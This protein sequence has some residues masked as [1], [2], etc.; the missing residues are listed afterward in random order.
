[1]ADQMLTTFRDFGLW[2]WV[3]DL[4]FSNRPDFKDQSP[5]STFLNPPN[6][7]NLWICLAQLVVGHRNRCGLGDGVPRC[8][9][10][11]QGNR[12]NTSVTSSRTFGTQSQMMRIDNLP[13][14]LCVTV[15]G[16]I[17]RLVA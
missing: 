13:I 17:D 15:S 12:V 6:L 3:F 2:T 1:M 9:S 7:R 16:A 5:K 14:G 11:G 8:V 10:T 4:W